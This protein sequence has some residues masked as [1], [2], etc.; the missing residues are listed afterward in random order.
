MNENLYAENILEHYRHPCAK[1]EL[2]DPT[3][4]HKEVNA[5]CGDI[6]ILH[7]KITDEKID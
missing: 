7:L 2:K 4:T 3:I 1:G 6:I 5:S